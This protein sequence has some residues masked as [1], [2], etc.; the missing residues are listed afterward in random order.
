M[1]LP[2]SREF[3]ALTSPNVFDSLPEDDL[4]SRLIDSYFGFPSEA[5]PLLQKSHFLR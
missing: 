5:M 4:A 2:P 3:Y 1:P